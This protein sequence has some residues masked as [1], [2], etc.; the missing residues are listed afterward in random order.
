MV[1]RLPQVYGV[2]IP[3]RPKDKVTTPVADAHRRFWNGL[4]VVVVR[5][6]P[7]LCVS[8]FSIDNELYLS[9]GW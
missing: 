1:E 8:C 4:H 6:R 3:W 9:V 5:T 2:E 7:S